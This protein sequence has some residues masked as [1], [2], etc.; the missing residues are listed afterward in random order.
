MNNALDFS[1]EQAE[2]LRLNTALE[3]TNEELE[4]LNRDLESCV[5]QRTRELRMRE[6]TLKMVLDN[7]DLDEVLK[8]VENDL[9]QLSLAE[10]VKI[11]IGDG[12][13]MGSDTLIPVLH[14]GNQVGTLVFKSAPKASEKSIQ[15]YLAIVEM[16]LSMKCLMEEKDTIIDNIDSL[17]K[18][19]E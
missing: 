17:L 8:K 12:K 1:R 3:K 19:L 14:L 6:E 18:T 13:D 2:N 10:E 7:K 4:R 5:Q 15:G 16:L 11:V 9:C